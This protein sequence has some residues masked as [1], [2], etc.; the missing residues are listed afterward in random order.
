MA[1]AGTGRRLVRAAGVGLVLALLVGGV[2]MAVAGL[3]R[4][5]DCTGLSPEACGLETGLVA[6]VRRMQGLVG[7]GLV[8]L[9]LGLSLLLRPRPPGR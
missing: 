7:V 8:G 3:T 6:Q 2:G 5:V 9:A 4:R 1:E